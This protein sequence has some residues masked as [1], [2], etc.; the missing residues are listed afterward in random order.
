MLLYLVRHGEA[1]AEEI[2]P[3][4][5]LTEKGRAEVEA[6]AKE[7]KAEG[8]RI[9]EIWHST[10][11]RAKQTAEIIARVLGVSKVIE[12]DGLKPSD[13]VAP[14]AEPL[15]Q[16]GKTILIAGHL[17]FLPKLASLLKTG[18]EE[19]GVSMEA[20]GWRTSGVMRVDI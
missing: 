11:L 8:A 6:T 15:R 16:S 1:V 5:P 18:A 13:P 2:D 14:I 9:D 12:K 3:A 10:K 19:K 20:E 4:R 17:P 7:L